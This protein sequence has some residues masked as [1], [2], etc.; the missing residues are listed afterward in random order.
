MA[1]I[2]LTAKDLKNRTG[3]AFRA[4]GRGDRVVL[5]RRGKALAVMVPLAEGEEVP[6]LPPYAEAWAD[7]EQAL[8]AS[9]PEF[10]SVDEAMARSRRRA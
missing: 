7:I 3:D 2:T 6:D 8:A 9:A 5:T 4:I 10:P 1:T